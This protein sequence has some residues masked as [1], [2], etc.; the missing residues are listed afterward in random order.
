VV[1][2]PFQI[3]STDQVE[4]GAGLTRV[5]A[6]GG[7]LG[8][9]IDTRVRTQDARIEFVDESSGAVLVSSAET[10]DYFGGLSLSYVQPLLRG[11]GEQVA[12]AA[13]RRS[14]L[15]KNTALLRQE[16]AALDMVRTIVQGYWELAY[17][18]DEL[19][20]RRSSLGLAQEQLRIT[21]AG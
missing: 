15:Q 20:I 8:L 11:F 9:N 19:E 12:R 3:T 1:G 16:V 13:R 10:T 2:Q 5:F 17:L 7:S 4:L 6:W 18:T 14:Q 21:R